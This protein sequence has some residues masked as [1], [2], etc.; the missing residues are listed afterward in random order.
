VF[1]SREFPVSFQDAFNITISVSDTIVPAEMSLA[2]SLQAELRVSEGIGMYLVSNPGFEFLYLS[3]L[4]LASQIHDVAVRLIILFPCLLD[5]NLE[6]PSSVSTGIFAK[7]G[8]VC[9]L[10]STGTSWL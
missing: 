2:Q 8:T 7:S 10:G 9:L 1:D 6:Y 4:R 3:P 5:C